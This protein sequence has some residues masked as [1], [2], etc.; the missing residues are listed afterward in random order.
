MLVQDPACGSYADATLIGV[1]LNV[2]KKSGH[3][4]VPRVHFEYPLAVTS[5]ACSSK[6]PCVGYAVKYAKVRKNGIPEIFLFPSRGIVANKR[7]AKQVSRLVNLGP[8][9][10]GRRMNSAAMTRDLTSFIVRLAVQ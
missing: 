1:Q 5:F 7:P 10:L 9:N 6:L 4:I 2:A 3:T 8:K